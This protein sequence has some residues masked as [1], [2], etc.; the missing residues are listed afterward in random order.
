MRVKAEIEPALKAWQTQ[1]R[2]PKA[3]VSYI[4]SSAVFIEA[5]FSFHSNT[6]GTFKSQWK[7]AMWSAAATAAADNDG[8]VFFF[9]NIRS[10]NAEGIKTMVS[11]CRAGYG[12]KLRIKMVEDFFIDL[13]YA[14]TQVA[15]LKKPILS[16]LCTSLFRI[17][18][19]TF[20]IQRPVYMEVGTSGRRVN[21]R[22]V[23]LPIMK[24]CSK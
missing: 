18:C 7:T 16:W 17:I 11:F 10:H 8:D 9:D 22:R 15:L 4:T 19:A 6:G 1:N 3:D 23:T 5:H 2:S 12:P 13:D 24:K 20:G 21:P 14:R